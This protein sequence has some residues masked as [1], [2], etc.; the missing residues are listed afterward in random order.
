M[1]H[2]DLPPPVAVAEGGHQTPPVVLHLRFSVRSLLVAITVASFVFAAAG[3]LGSVWSISIVLLALISG[4]HVL[5]N[6]LGTRLRDQA[7]EQHR[8]HGPDYEAM[9]RNFAA[10]V[11]GPHSLQALAASQPPNRLVLRESLGRLP[12]AMVLLGGLAGGCLA[13]AASHYYY[14][15][16]GVGDRV[17][18]VLS[19]AVLGGLAA[20]AASTFVQVALWPACR[21]YFCRGGRRKRSAYPYQ[22]EARASESA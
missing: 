21:F 19:F 20:F 3:W 13:M 15:H 17:I 5:G 18:V 16:F 22:H 4:A 1:N 12:A 14:S 10:R 2:S 7:T 9:R 11:D 6:A 8:R